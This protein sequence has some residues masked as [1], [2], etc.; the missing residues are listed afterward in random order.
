MTEKERKAQVSDRLYKQP[1]GSAVAMSNVAS[2]SPRC[3][4]RSMTEGCLCSPLVSSAIGEDLRPLVDWPPLSDL[5][6]RP[7]CTHAHETVGSLFRLSRAASSHL[8]S[9]PAS[10][11]EGA[12]CG[13]E[14]DEARLCLLACFDQSER[15]SDLRV[16]PMQC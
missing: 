11:I 3:S 12:E 15:E 1:S 16:A 4:Q 14:A 2:G 13:V 5:P 6:A 7:R 9:F 8:V 10:S